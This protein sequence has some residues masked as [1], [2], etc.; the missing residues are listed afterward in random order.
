VCQGAAGA[1]VQ[2]D[3]DLKNVAFTGLTYDNNGRGVVYRRQA[4]TNSDYDV[5][6][7]L[8][9]GTCQVGF[10]GFC[11]GEAIPDQVGGKFLD[12]QWFI[13]PD[14][15]GY[16]AGAVIQSLPPGTIGQTPANCNG[17]RTEPTTVQLTSRLNPLSTGIETFTFDAPNAVTVG[18]AALLPTKDGKEEWAQIGADA[19]AADGFKVDWT[20]PAGISPGAGRQSIPV[21]Y[22]VCWA[23][24]TP[25]RANGLVGIQENGQTITEPS[26]GL[27]N[28]QV[29]RGAARACFDKAGGV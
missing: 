28:D 19:S 15:R 10:K 25:G 11:I 24:N 23:G 8:L 2:F 20:P 29:L 13:L 4:N 9:P 6:G 14:D 26:L 3:A 22:T 12:Q 18:V 27:T 21:L 16:V 5:V 17:G 1:G 7:R